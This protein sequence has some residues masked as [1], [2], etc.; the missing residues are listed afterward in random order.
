MKIAT[1][2]ISVGGFDAV[3]SSADPGAFVT[4]MAQQRQFAPGSDVAA[5]QLSPTD[6]VLDL[7]CGPGSDSKV[8]G[9][10]TEHVVGLD[11]SVSAQEVGN[12][13]IRDS[14]ELRVPR[15]RHAARR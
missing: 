9:E 6:R 8:L 15:V 11:L 13:G 7:G 12:P 14:S 3:E 2:L 5:L 10:H 1:P 4:W